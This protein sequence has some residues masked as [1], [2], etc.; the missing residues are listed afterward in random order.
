MPHVWLRRKH[1]TGVLMQL[2]H[3]EKDPPW[4]T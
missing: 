4:S 2:G 1:G 3:C